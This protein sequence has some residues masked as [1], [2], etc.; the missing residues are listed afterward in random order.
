MSKSNVDKLKKQNDDLKTEINTLRD[1][2]QTIKGKLKSTPDNQELER[3]VAFLSEEYDDLQH[4][5][6]S[7]VLELKQFEGKLN[8][9]DQKVEELDEAIESIMRYSYQYN[10]KLV[11]IPQVSSTS[12][13]A[14]ETVNLCLKVFS[15]MGANISSH[16]IDIAHRTPNKYQSNPAPIICKFTRRIA[17]EAVLSKRK[18]VN[19]IDFDK[20]GL[21]VDTERSSYIAIYEHLTPKQQVLLKQAKTYQK[22]NNFAYC[23]VK[24]Q[25][26]LLREHHNSKILRI[27]KSSDLDRLIWNPT[28]EPTFT[29]ATTAT[30]SP[31][32]GRGRALRGNHRGGVG[33]GKIGPMQAFNSGNRPI[34]RST[35]VSTQGETHSTQVTE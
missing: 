12:E 31:L 19:N 10:L 13:T 34:T 18:E 2:L 15:E 27:S 26:I 14:E 24:N 35:S 11:G 16:D 6:G 8:V 23:W 21:P 28:F 7:I 29:P 9:I 3:S 32:P 17:K 22:Q 1:E 4:D 30:T 33:R 5:R 20:I 25:T